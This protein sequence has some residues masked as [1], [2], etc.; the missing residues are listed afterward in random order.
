MKTNI[1]IAI[2]AAVLISSTMVFAEI[3]TGETDIM[4]LTTETV[5]KEALDISNV[6]T[7]DKDGTKMVPLREVAEGILGLEVKWINET[8]SVEIGSG[9]QWTSITIDRNSYFFARVAPF[10]LSQAPELK[11]NLTYVPMEFFTEVLKY[12]V[13]SEPVVPDEEQIM[14]GFIKDIFELDGRIRILVAGDQNA[15]GLDLALFYIAE[16]T[17]MVD[18]NGNMFDAGDLKVGT[19]VRVTLPEIMALSYP[20]QGTAVKIVVLNTDIHIENL[21]D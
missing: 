4:P 2:I 21:I 10:E 11:D 9:P 17:M 14:L 5:I 13:K 18:V 20:P 7:Y 15:S 19:K 6:Q 8:H 1:T 16:E 3:G 12:E